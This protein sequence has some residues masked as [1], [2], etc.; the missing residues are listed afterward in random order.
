MQAFTPT[1]SRL[2]GNCPPD[3]ELAAYIDGVLDKEEADRVAGHL[4]SC[5]RCHEIYSEVLQFQLDSD[6]PENVV[7]FPPPEER[8]KAAAAE[9]LRRPRIAARWFSIA[10]LLLVGVGSGVYFWFLKTP[11]TLV[12]AD[13]TASLPY[14]PETQ[15]LWT[16]PRHRGIEDEEIGIDEASFRLGV[17]FVNLQLSLKANDTQDASD[18]IAFILNLLPSGSFTGDYQKD[19]T[20]VKTNLLNGKASVDLLPEAARLAQESRDAFDPTS[21]DLGQWVEAGRLAALAGTPL[22][23]HPHRAG[24]AAVSLIRTTRR[25]GAGRSRPTHAGCGPFRA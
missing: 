21:L 5:E 3:E 11:P 7:P 14:R 22:R 15:N 10:A 9:D 2:T 18:A 16:G 24:R 1:K 19:Y 12:T 17:Q 25:R 20:A 8:G 6:L 23:R 4:I 13:V